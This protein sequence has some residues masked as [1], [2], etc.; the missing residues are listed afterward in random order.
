MTQQERWMEKAR[1]LAIKIGDDYI[2][3][4]D[5]LIDSTTI[6][7]RK[8]IAEDILSA[9]SDAYAAGY[10]EGRKEENGACAKVIENETG[11]NNNAWQYSPSRIA[12]AIR[13]RMKDANANG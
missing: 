13:N 3:V 8:E 12:A 11:Y 4:K 5:G 6:V 7:K 9:L 10:A 1:N 2:T